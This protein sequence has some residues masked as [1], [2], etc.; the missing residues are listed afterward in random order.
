MQTL[1]NPTKVKGGSLL[2][3]LTFVR[4]HSGEDGVRRVLERL[5]AEDRQT[6]SQVLT[7][8]WYASGLGERLDEAVAAEM[9]MGEQVFLL[10]GE[11]S[12]EQNLTGPHRALLSAGDPH[13]LLRRAP[14]IYQMYYDTGRRTYE[15][16]GDHKAV[17][18]TH[19]AATFSKHDCLTVVGWHRKAIAMCDGAN[20]RVHETKCRA[21]GDEVCEYVCE[22]N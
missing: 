14:Q 16:L 7:G 9:G 8:G 2:S 3:R 20:P 17:V 21:A 13:G 5:S 15:R 11:K 6:C 22:W 12:A 19:D 4:D 10:M 18:R 1:T